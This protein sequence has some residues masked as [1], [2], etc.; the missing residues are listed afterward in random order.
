MHENSCSTDDKRSEV[1]LTYKPKNSM[2]P[3]ILGFGSSSQSCMSGGDAHQLLEDEKE[4]EHCKSLI[5]NACDTVDAPVVQPVKCPCFNRHDLKNVIWKIENNE[6]DLVSHDTEPFC[7]MHS[8]T[9]KLM[10]Y[11]ET[12]ESTEPKEVGFGVDEGGTL[13][14][15]GDVTGVTSKDT[16]EEEGLVCGNL[17]KSACMVFHRRS[18]P[19]AGV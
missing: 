1:E 16:N 18:L 2:Y 6:V 3:N 19:T 8:G 4:I 14:M 12:T 5:D 10:Y 9:Q 13:C 11:A 15:I 7:V 17:I